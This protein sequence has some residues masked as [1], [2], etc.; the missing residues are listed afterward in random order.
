MIGA[1]LNVEYNPPKFTPLK[2]WGAKSMAIMIPQGF[3]FRRTLSNVRLSIP[4][5]YC[6]WWFS[7]VGPTMGITHCCDVGDF[8]YIRPELL[9]SAICTHTC[10]CVRL[11]ASHPTCVHQVHVWISHLGILTLDPPLSSKSFSY[12]ATRCAPAPCISLTIR[13]R[14]VIEIFN[15]SIQL[16]SC[17]YACWDPCDA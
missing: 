12:E 7:Q 1:I 14:S 6:G 5:L 3:V 2:L 15:K 9:R 16:I 10:S 13:L 8:Y 11:V 4:L 17:L